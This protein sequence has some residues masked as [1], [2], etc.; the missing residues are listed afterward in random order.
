MAVNPGTTNL[1][2]H[3]RHRGVEDGRVPLQHPAVE[4]PQRADGL[5]HRTGRQVL[6]LDQMEEVLLELFLTQ[7][8]GRR[9]KILSQVGHGG[10]VALLRPW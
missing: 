8:I 1:A 10:H 3:P 9:M 4:G 6:V 5:V 7:L 2:F